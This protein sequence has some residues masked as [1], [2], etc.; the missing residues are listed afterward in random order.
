MA[1]LAT[2]SFEVIAREWL[3]KEKPGW[4]PPIIFILENS[5]SK[6]LRELQARKTALVKE[7]RALTDLATSQDRDLTTEDPQARLPPK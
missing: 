3:T 1:Q 4:A 6:Q 2:Q 7:A 5:M